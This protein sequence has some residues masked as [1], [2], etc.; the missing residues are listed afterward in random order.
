[1]GHDFTGTACA[2]A[3]PKACYGDPMSF[4]RNCFG[5]AVNTF[6]RDDKAVNNAAK[7]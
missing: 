1:M 5:G 2:T 3:N 4:L 6:E 7:P